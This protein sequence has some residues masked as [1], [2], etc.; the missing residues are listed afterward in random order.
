MSG[1]EDN[2]ALGVENET[3]RLILHFQ[4]YLFFFCTN[5]CWEDFLCSH[6]LP[7]STSTFSMR[8]NNIH[9]M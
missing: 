7:N 1:D 4:N 2:W 9:Q 6:I 3:E 8:Q 5:Q